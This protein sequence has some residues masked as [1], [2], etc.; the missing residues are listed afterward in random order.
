M[1]DSFEQ[2]GKYNYIFNQ[3]V[4]DENDFVGYVAYT[5]YKQNKVA[6]ITKVKEDKG[7]APTDEELR[8]WQ[9]KRVY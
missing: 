9:K 7:S 6:H 5:L 1:N 2:E 8:E 3:L 4:K